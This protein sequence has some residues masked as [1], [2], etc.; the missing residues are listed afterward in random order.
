M[1]F[2]EFS[3]L[4]LCG[5]FHGKVVSA[6][7]QLLLPDVAGHG[8]E[9]AHHQLQH[10]DEADLEVD[11]VVVRAC[12]RASPG[13]M[14]SHRDVSHKAHIPGSEHEATRVEGLVF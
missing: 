7:P 1:I 13:T 10:Y 9:D 11:E 6:Q 2:I 12:A 4:H 5:R 8:A 3:R 14:M